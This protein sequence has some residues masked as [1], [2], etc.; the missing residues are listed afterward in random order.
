M[1]PVTEIEGRGV[2]RRM[3][4]DTL[5][6]AREELRAHRVEWITAA[7]NT[8]SRFSWYWANWRSIRRRAIGPAT[9]INPRSSKS[10]RVPS[11]AGLNTH[12]PSMG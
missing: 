4:T 12:V 8:R 2:M 10:T 6:Y 5:R 3:C 11:P 7:E 9:R 1:F